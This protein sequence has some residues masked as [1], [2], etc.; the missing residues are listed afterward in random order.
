MSWLDFANHF[1]S[2]QRLHAWSWIN[3]T[4]FLGIVF[5]VGIWLWVFW[6]FPFLFLF[7]AGWESRQ[8]TGFW[9]A[10]KGR[11]QLQVVVSFLSLFGCGYYVLFGYCLVQRS[12]CIFLFV[13]F[14]SL[15]GNF[16]CFFALFQSL[17]GKFSYFAFFRSL[18]GNFFFLSF[19]FCFLPRARMDILTLGQGLWWVGILAQ[20]L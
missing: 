14:W 13:F 17:I 11:G 19:F 4:F 6:P 5:L 20:S 15:I 1:L 10:T 18:I 7:S 12:F 3:R 2:N 8:C 16:S 9:S